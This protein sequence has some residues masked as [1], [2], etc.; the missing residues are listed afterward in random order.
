MVSYAWY[1]ALVHQFILQEIAPNKLDIT[2]PKGSS[3]ETYFS[4]GKV[5]CS[6]RCGSSYRCA[7]LINQLVTGALCMRHPHF[8]LSI[9]ERV[10]PP[11][12]AISRTGVMERTA[13]LTMDIGHTATSVESNR[14]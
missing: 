2:P 4:G 11:D 10:L 8:R 6:H 9:M 3:C 13:A 7:V 5:N 1:G 12:R 14:Q